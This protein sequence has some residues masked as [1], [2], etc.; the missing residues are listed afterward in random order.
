MEWNIPLA[1]LGQLP[2][3]YLL[4]LLV[5]PCLLAGRMVQEAETLLAQQKHHYAIKTVFLLKPKRQ[6]PPYYEENQLCPS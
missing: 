6:I 2:W 4:P 1:R 3:F 5:P